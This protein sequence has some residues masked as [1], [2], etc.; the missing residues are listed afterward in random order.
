MAVIVF[1]LTALVR[2]A[3]A[4]TITDLG[5]LGGGAT[6]SAAVG[7][8]ASG[9][10][11]GSST[12]TAGFT[13]AFLYS[14]GIMTDLGPF[15][16]PNSIAYGINDSGQVVGFS[17]AADLASLHAFLYSGGVSDRPGHARRLQQHCRWN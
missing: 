9:Q 14:G 4:A 2:P 8:N 7:I 6:T 13:H 17:E 12:T 5:T 1:C 16:S 11:V 3:P 10:V 15:A